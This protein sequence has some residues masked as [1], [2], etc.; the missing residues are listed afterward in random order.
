MCPDGNVIARKNR[1]DLRTG[2][3][4]AI[5]CRSDWKVKRQDFQ[6]D[7]ECV[8]WEIITATS[9]YQ[10][11]AIWHPPDPIYTDVELLDHLSNNCEP[12]FSAKPNTRIII[13][14]AKCTGSY[15]PTQP[16]PDGQESHTGPWSVRRVSDQLSTLLETTCCV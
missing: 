2:G 11:A 6:K 4:V 14:P 16:S 7:L 9:E 5:I 10:V 13:H 8:W 12:I 1:S 3:G 15:E